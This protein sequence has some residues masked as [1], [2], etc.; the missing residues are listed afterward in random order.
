MIELGAAGVLLM[1]VYMAFRALYRLITGHL[2]KR[3]G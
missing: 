2:P 3:S 1:L